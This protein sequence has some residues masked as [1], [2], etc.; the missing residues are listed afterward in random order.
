MLGRKNRFNVKTA[1]VAVA[2]T[3][4]PLYYRAPRGKK[5]GGKWQ[6][7]RDV[8]T[9]GSAASSLSIVHPSQAGTPVPNSQNNI[10][11][12]IKM[13]IHSGCEIDINII[14]SKKVSLFSYFF[15]PPAYGGNYEITLTTRFIIVWIKFLKT[16]KRV[17]GST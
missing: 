10:N 1:H 7:R 5:R 14:D 2:M 3:L 4:Y 9:R 12:I 6:A 11:I 16:R 17:G 15:N 13:K 8:A